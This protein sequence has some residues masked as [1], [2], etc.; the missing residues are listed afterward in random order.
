MSIEP[1]TKE[2]FVDCNFK[3]KANLMIL[4]IL[5]IIKI[6]KSHIKN[7]I[8]LRLIKMKIAVL[9]SGGVDSSVALKVLKDKGHEVIAFY[10]KIWLEDELSF[11]GDCPWEEDL[12]YAKKVCKQLGVPLKICPMQKEYWEKI[13]DYVLSEAKAGRTPSPDILCNQFIKFGLF[14]DRI[15]SS[16]DKV[17]TGHYSVVKEEGGLF[18]LY[19]SPDPIKDQSYFLSRLSQYQL[20]RALF[21]ISL[22]VFL[23]A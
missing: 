1:S 2:G 6:I 19:R 3:L 7:L 5:G 17:A 4:I 21:P 14:F 8:S 16:F 22:A 9:V 10:L 13:V 18:H 20:S 11:L 12:S 15:D 23:V